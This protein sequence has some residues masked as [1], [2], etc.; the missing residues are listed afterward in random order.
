MAKN[1]RKLA[2][3]EFHST[4]LALPRLQVA[5][6]HQ[7][8]KAANQLLELLNNDEAR[9]LAKL[10]GFQKFNPWF[11]RKLAETNPQP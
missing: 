7:I 2:K 8:S 10:K 3:K 6:G 1:H 5:E 11:K 4:F 9:Y